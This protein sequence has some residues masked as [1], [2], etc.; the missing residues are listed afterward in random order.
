M[1]NITVLVL[2][3]AFL[4]TGCQFSLGDRVGVNDNS[5]PKHVTLKLKWLHQ[6]QFAGNYVAKEEG[7]YRD[8]G[9]N[10]EISP[11]SFESPTI[12]SVVH[13]GVNFGITGADE[14]AIARKN[15]MPL[16]ALAVIYKI[17]PVCAYSLKENN[18]I[19]PS[20]FIGKTVGIE[21]AADGTEINIGITYH[22]MMEKVGIDRSQINEITI[23]YDATELI[24]GTVDVSTGYI[25]N[26]PHLAEAAG[27]EVNKILMADY[28]VNMYADVIF[29]REDFIQ[30]NPETVDSFLR[31]TIRGWEWSINNIEQATNHVLKYATDRTFE[32][33][34]FMLRAS[35]PL[36]LGR[37]S[38]I[39][40]MNPGEWQQLVDI[41][42]DQGFI[43]PGSVQIEDL[44]EDKFIN[45][46][47]E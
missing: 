7:F 46:I 37:D 31:A 2:I 14:L 24:A 11:F 40:Q 21:R 35:V 30:D 28:G 20:D 45:K 43:E 26:E 3:Y 47:Y 39:G 29:A 34:Q 4:L 38:V 27:Y 23:G 10:V 33:E 25:I 22:A 17:S 41:L 8:V 6:A 36:I 5:N 9:L 19:R 32:H 1:R 16:K 13:G 15:G 12:P 44:Y 18:I 42:T